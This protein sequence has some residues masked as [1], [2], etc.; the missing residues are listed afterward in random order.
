M[1]G[2]ALLVIDLQ[3]RLLDLIPDS[4][5]IVKR[6]SFVIECAHL[7]G[8]PVVYTEQVP[9]KL[10][11]T[12]PALIAAGL[13]KVDCF[14]KSSFSA[15][16][17]PGLKDKLKTLGVE[18]LLVCG[19]EAGVCVFQTVQE[20][21]DDGIGV[22]LLTDCIQG[23]RISDSNTVMDFLKNGPSACLPSETVFYS[24]IK[25]ADHP[26]FSSFNKVVKKYS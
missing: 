21:L 7:L 9:S 1:N 5:Q 16:G 20:A 14:S 25:D 19:I 22:T 24:M 12:H 17:A 3:E 18:H 15:M 8:I 13:D 10:G 26:H 23:R 11:N 6:C 2:L 4:E